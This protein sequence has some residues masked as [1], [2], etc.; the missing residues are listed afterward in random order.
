M[1]CEINF[2]QK[3]NPNSPV[4]N[5]WVPSMSSDKAYDVMLILQDGGHSVSNL[6]PVSDL[7]TSDV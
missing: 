6:L 4:P 5:T 3:S 2:T 7:A 1:L